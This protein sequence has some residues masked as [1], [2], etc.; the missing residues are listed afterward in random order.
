MFSGLSLIILAAYGRSTLLPVCFLYAC[1]NTISR[2]TAIPGSFLFTMGALPIYA[3][4]APL[5]NFSLPF[6]GIVPRL[7][8][9]A[10]FYF[11]LL[12]FPIVCLLRDYA[13]K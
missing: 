6:T 7:W 13:W 8:A 9:D 1:M 2:P 4:I 3:I 12:L 5:L 10:V 11:V